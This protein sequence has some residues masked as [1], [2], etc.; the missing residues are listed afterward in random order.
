MRNERVKR[1]VFFML[2]CFFNPSSKAIQ[3][4]DEV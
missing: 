3:R 4:N 2:V 1:V